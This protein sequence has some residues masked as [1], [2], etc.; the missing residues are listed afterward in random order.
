MI[1]KELGVQDSVTIDD[2]E[3]DNLFIVATGSQPRMVRLHF[4]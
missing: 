4:R 3:Y 2:S 1:L